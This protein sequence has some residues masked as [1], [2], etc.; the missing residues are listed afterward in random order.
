MKDRGYG[1]GDERRVAKPSVEREIPGGAEDDGESEK[2]PAV[3]RSPE[4]SDMLPHR[5]ISA[6]PFLLLA[7][8]GT[9]D[10]SRN[11]G[12]V[13]AGS[14]PGV[15]RYGR[16]LECCYGWKRNRSGQ[17]EAQCEHG[18]KHGECVGPNK[19]KCFPGYTGKTCNQDLN[20]CGLKPRPCEHRCMNTHGS[21]KCYCLNG[22]SLTPDGSC[23]NSRTCA[24]AH[25]Q[26]G[27]EEVQGE[28][29]CLCPSA[30]L[31]L[32]PDGRNCVD[33][34][35]CAS[36]KNLCPY[37][38]RCV[39]TFGS[40]YCKCQIGYDLKYFDGKYDCA[41]IDECATA[42]HTCSHHAECLNTQGSYRCRCKPGFRGNGIECSIKPFYQNSWDGER[43]SADE[44][45]NALPDSPI[46]LPRV[47]GGGKLENVIPEPEVTTTPRIR[48]QP[49]DY[50]GEV[51]IGNPEEEQSNI[52][53]KEEE[54]G[55]ENQENQ[56]ENGALSPRGDV[57]TPESVFGP[58]TEVKEIPVAAGQEEFIMD[59][60]FDQGACEW[61][62]D[63]EDDF[64][65]GVAY[66]DNGM[67][68]YMAASALV[69]E[70]KD[71]ARLR[72]LLSDRAQKGSFCLTFN[73]RLVGAQVGSLRVLLDNSRYAVW[74]QSRRRD[75][76]WH[77]ELITVAWEQEAPQSII[78]EAERGTGVEGEI[79]LDNVVLTSGPCQEDE[80]VI[81]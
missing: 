28:M 79:E 80:P 18:C 33:I 37:N 71:L 56:V 36:G 78:F 63:K 34:D 69:G 41:D 51:Y 9:A 70:A 54:G 39:N 11:A 5:W 30:G 72:L 61:V 65:W 35:E 38:R 46:K 22:Y 25:C 4:P 55:E 10:L 57:F 29:R 12:Q 62:Q 15:C 8:C 64:D 77:T 73:Y 13:Q 76:D 14:H 50:D 26:Y 60:N 58:V 74:E 3:N 27:C 1:D 6:L 66:H 44:S 49:F 47:L 7:S 19:C 75:S 40:Y 48:L 16:R 24:L 42:V 21:Y 20:E 59:C 53:E 43:G 67:G 17:C 81:F 32:A 2:R 31:Q 45:L 52:P 23:I 68:N